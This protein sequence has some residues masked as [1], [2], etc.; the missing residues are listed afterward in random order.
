[1]KRSWVEN[2]CADKIHL[3]LG[4]CKEMFYEIDWTGCTY[5][6]PNHYWI[7]DKEK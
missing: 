7:E 5:I 3:Y 4:A 6:E 1:M 2:K